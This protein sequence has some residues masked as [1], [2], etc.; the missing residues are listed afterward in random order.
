L[1]RCVCKWL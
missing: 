1:Y